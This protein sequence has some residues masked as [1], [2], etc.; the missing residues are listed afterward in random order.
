MKILTASVCSVFLF[1]IQTLTTSWNQHAAKRWHFPARSF[2]QH[3][4]DHER[5]GARTVPECR[6]TLSGGGWRT[7]LGD[8]GALYAPNKAAAP[9]RSPP[10]PALFAT[11]CRGGSRRAALGE[12]P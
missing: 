6:P 10:G 12:R 9:L 11:G 8:G 1:G 3:R 7:A 4:E 2:S 5:F